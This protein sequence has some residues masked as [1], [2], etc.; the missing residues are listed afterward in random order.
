L[1]TDALFDGSA[2]NKISGRMRKIELLRVDAGKEVSF[3]YKS[4]RAA[5]RFIEQSL[6]PGPVLSIT[7]VWANKN[8][9]KE[10]QIVAATKTKTF[11]I[12]ESG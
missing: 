8:I 5:Y 11:M 3:R 9:S 4:L 12:R 7:R 10:W 2:Y 6:E 1:G